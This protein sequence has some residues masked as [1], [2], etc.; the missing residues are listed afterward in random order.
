MIRNWVEA[1]GDGTRSTSTRPPR[2]GR[3]RRHRRA[4]RDGPGVDDARPATRAGAPDDPLRPDDEHPRRGGLHLGGRHQLRADLPPLPA[5]SASRSRVD[6]RARRR[7]RA[8]ADRRSARAGSSPR[9]TTWYVGDEPVA[10]MLFRVLKFEPGPAAA[11]ARTGGRR[12]TAGRSELADTAFFWDG[13][14]AGELRIQ[15]LPRCGA[16][17][18]PPGPA[19]CPAA[20]SHD[21]TTSWRR[22][23]HGLQLRRAPRT[24][25]C[26]GKR[27]PFVVAL[28]ELDE[29]VRMVGELRGRRP[30]RGRRSGCRSQVAFDRGRRR[31]DAARLEAA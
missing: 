26:P 16:L 25:R 7:R 1:I 31:A 13:T 28:V 12:S 4:A 22:A 29:G 17:R 24:R 23:R 11:P 19:L 2:R 8:E 3:A 27:L 10:E 30:G 6:Q 14:A 21:R 20:R 5:A 15:Q 9:A 18:H